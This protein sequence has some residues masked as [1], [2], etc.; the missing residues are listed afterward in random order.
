MTKISLLLCDAIELFLFCY[1]R[2]TSKDSRDRDYS[3]KERD[4][5]DYR[6][7]D[8]RDREYRDKDRPSGY[9]GS[10]K[11]HSNSRSR[12]PTHD[13]DL[14]PHKRRR[15]EGKVASLGYLIKK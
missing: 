13:T 8:V 2:T 4:R 15:G 5:N 9:S 1:F 10:S 7:K 6:E 14:P 11:S 3:H 12:W